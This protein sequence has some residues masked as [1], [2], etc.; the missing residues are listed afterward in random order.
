MSQFEPIQTLRT[1]RLAALERDNYEEL[2][3][4]E[5]EA[6]FAEGEEEEEDCQ[7]ILSLSSTG[8]LIVF[9]SWHKE[10]CDKEKAWIRGSRCGC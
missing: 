3:P 5:K 2:P 10:A 8:S 6:H 7:F 4:E 9:R 1:Q